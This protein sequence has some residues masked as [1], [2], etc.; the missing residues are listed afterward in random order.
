MA[1]SA[2]AFE[3]GELEVYQVLACKRAARPCALPLT[4]QHLYDA[5]TPAALT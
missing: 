4:R 3:T 5:A 2:L 1:A